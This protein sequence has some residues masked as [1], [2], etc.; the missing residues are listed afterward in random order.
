MEEEKRSI[1]QS[2]RFSMDV[3]VS[4]TNSTAAPASEPICVLRNHAISTTTR[5]A[6]DCTLV[7]SGESSPVGEFVGN[8]GPEWN[9]ITSA[10]LPVRRTGFRF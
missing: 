6:C 5:W 10:V 4:Y 3:T 2:C 1:V 9:I 7:S 8:R